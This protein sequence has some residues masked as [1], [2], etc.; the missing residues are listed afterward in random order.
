MHKKCVCVF[1]YSQPKCFQ[2]DI[3]DKTEGKS[4]HDGTRG[5]ST[6]FSTYALRACSTDLI[7]FVSKRRSLESVTLVC[8]C[9]GVVQS[10]QTF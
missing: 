4:H 3:I 9:R 2:P 8:R 6:L 1:V 5:Y 10:T 7:R